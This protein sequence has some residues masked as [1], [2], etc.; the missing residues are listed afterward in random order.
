MFC[1]RDHF[2]VK[3]F[4][5]Y[6][7][8]RLFAFASEIKG[9]LC[10]PDVPH[11]LNEV[12]VADYLV[13]MFDDKEI[14]FYQGILRLPPAHSMTV[15]RTGVQLKPYWALDATREIRYRSNEE[16]ADAF[17]E[18]FTEAVR[19]RLRSAYPVGSMLSGGLD[20]SSVV[21]VARELLAGQGNG[22][23]HTFSA[24]FDDVPEC[25]ESVYF[26]AV[27]AQGGL[28]PHYVP[29][30]RVNRGSDLD[31]LL[32]HQDEPFSAPYAFLY[33]ALY[34]DAHDHGVRVVL[35]GI[36]GDSAVS[37]GV[38]Y[39]TELACAGRWVALAS[40][41]TSF[42]R[43]RNSSSWAILRQWVLR[44]L[45]PALIL[46]VART[47]R[48]RRGP[49]WGADTIVN[50]AF[51]QQIGLAARYE[52]LRKP[53]LK[54]ARTSKEHHLQWLTRGVY[55]F[56]LEVIDRAA[57]AH[58][59]EPR[60]VCFD[61]RLAEFCLAL[62]GEQKLSQ[63]WTRMV[64]RRA[65]AGV[66]PEEVRSRVGKSGLSPAFTRSLLD[67]NGR[68]AED[69]I[70]KDTDGISKYVDLDVIRKAC[71][72][73]TS[74]GDYNDVLKVWWTAVL[75]AWLRQAELIACGEGESDGE[76]EKKTRGRPEYTGGT[77]ET[78]SRA[79]TDNPRHSAGP[80]EDRYRCTY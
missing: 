30:E 76:R 6:R 70:L 32:W 48:G 73:S 13:P 25:D 16:Y 21:C 65:M 9:L 17:R 27:A 69:V 33:R 79:E 64:M 23:L 2:G 78:L 61:I 49:P 46:Q 72:R 74:Q 47:L 19:C 37:H 59:V 12:R 56:M 50:P 60:H 3:P 28:E 39:L 35:D 75:V 80:Y 55:P 4:Y 26:K 34:R 54:P 66:L 58:S 22:R 36:D 67:C 20:S 7:S 63:G 68:S 57:A 77:K 11:R 14:T 38:A 29:G 41:V 62:P 52:E 40:E 10:V 15:S 44:P 42:A 45:V 1:A 71:E 24:V 18:I 43:R 53:R 8:D 31:H 51:A 5:Y